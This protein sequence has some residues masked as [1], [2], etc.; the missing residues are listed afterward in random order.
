MIETKDGHLDND[1]FKARVKSDHQLD[2]LAG[3]MYCYLIVFQSK[4]PD[5]P[6]ANFYDR[7]IEIVKWAV[8]NG[9]EVI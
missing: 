1:E 2:I 7:F 3:S 5:Y 6:S 8:R 9:K 4:T